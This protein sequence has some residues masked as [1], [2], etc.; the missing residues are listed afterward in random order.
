MIALLLLAAAAAAAPA[1]PF[2]LDRTVE[3]GEILAAADFRAQP[4]LAVAPGVS[5]AQADGR[6]AVRRLAEGAVV[7]AADLRAP[8]LVKRGDSVVIA[9]QSGA[10]S[11]T[12]QGRALSAGGIGDPVRVT[13]TASLRTVQAI[14]D[15][16]RRVKILAQ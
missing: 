13:S 9:I 4:D 12:A 5:P 7:R 1:G 11:I 8:Q 6:E 16:P 2:V 3:A 15:G 14:V 10:L